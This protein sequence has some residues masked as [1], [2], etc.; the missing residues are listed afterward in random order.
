[1]VARRG[2]NIGPHCLESWTL[3]LT[4][5]THGFWERTFEMEHTGKWKVSWFIHL[6]GEGCVNGHQ[7]TCQQWTVQ[8]CERGPGAQTQGKRCLELD[9]D[10]RPAKPRT[11]IILSGQ[12]RGSWCNLELMWQRIT[13]DFFFQCLRGKGLWGTNLPLFPKIFVIIVS[14]MNSLLFLC[15]LQFLNLNSSSNDKYLNGYFWCHTLTFSF[16]LLLLPRY[17]RQ[18]LATK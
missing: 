3:P 18:K 1:M 10:W 16:P 17:F 4:F 13:G 2:A 11:F 9:S 12:R 6:P 14:T 15:Y 8:A 5:S 7:Q